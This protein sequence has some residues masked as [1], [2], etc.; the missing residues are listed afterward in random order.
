MTTAAEADDIDADKAGEQRR[1]LPAAWRAIDRAIVRATEFA[2]FAI[3][4]LFTILVS[5]EVLSRYVFQFSIMFVNAG[6]RFLLVWFFVVGAG[7]ALRRGAHV[8]FELLVS[9]VR[10][11]RQRRVVLGAQAL[12]MLFFAEMIWAGVYSL[13]PAWRQ[14]EPGLEVSLVWAFLSIP[15]GFAL[16]AYHMAVLMTVEIRQ[17]GPRP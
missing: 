1:H 4:A 7:L 11:G 12:A 17:T 14:I 5:L 15:A 2:V 16:L 13:G 8:G 3:G 10:R 9:R 6:A